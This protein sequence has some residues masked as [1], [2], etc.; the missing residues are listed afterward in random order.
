MIDRVL[1]TPLI[2]EAG[3]GLYLKETRTQVFSCVYCEV[4]KNTFLE[5]R[6]ILSAKEENKKHSLLMYLM[7]NIHQ[8]PI[9]ISYVMKKITD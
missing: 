4:V 7:L 9:Y 2:S 5:E 1:N 3:L 8:I 6:E